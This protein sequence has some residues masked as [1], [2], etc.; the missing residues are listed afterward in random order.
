MED[1]KDVLEHDVDRDSGVHILHIRASH[2]ETR[3]PLVVVDDEVDEILEQDD[4]PRVVINLECVEF[5][6]TTALAKL[7]SC[8][9]KVAGSGGSVSLCCVQPQVGEVFEVTRFDEIFNIFDSQ[10]AAVKNT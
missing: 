10:E 4:E 2:L 7:I 8:H 1:A 6:A 5:L 3:M 9:E